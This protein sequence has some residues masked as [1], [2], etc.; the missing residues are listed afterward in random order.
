MNTST[1]RTMIAAAALVVAAGTASAQ[2]YR[3]EVP[4]SFRVAS[5]TMPAGSYD[6][7]MTSNGVETVV[8]YNRSTQTAVAVVSNVRGDAPRQWVAAG[9]P[10]LTFSCTGGTCRLSTLFTGS[11]AFAYSFPAPR[12]PAGNVV[13]SRTEVVT[14]SMIRTH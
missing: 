14:L 9:D 4:V 10:K 13:A 3:A 5:R 1:I 7:R 12:P 6:I 11:D 2:S 8:L